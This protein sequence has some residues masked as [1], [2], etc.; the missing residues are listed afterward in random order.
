MAP[1][2]AAT[3]A[4]AAAVIIVAA[5]PAPATNVVVASDVAAHMFVLLLTVPLVHVH[6]PCAHLLFCLWYLTVKHN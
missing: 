1:T 6:P 5:T 4:A 3:I 2:L